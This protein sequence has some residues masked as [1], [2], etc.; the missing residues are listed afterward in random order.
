VKTLTNAIDYEQFSNAKGKRNPKKVKLLY[1]G[2]ISFE[3]RIDVA[4]QA[5]FLLRKNHSN[6]ELSIIG[7][8]PATESLKELAKELGVGKNVHFPGPFR[9]KEL[10][11]R[12]KG[13]DILVAPSPMETQGLYVLEAMAAGLCVV[14][15]DMRAIPLAIGKNERGLLFKN[16]NAEDCAEK[17]EKLMKNPHLR[18]K[19]VTHAKKWVKGYGRKAIAKEWLALYRSL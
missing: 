15:C 8:G 17:I 18:K 2:R 5:L 19:L 12:V 6:V 10:A 1:Y 7:N 16:G 11:K 3:K 9:G 14:G 4:V 13:H